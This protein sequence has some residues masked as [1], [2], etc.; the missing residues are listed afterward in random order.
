MK[1]H[2]IP[3]SRYGWALLSALALAGCQTAEDRVPAG[4]S[5][6]AHLLIDMHVHAGGSTSQQTWA[7][8]LRGL[9]AHGPTIA[10]LSVTETDV[11]REWPEAGGTRFLLGPSFPCHEGRYPR[12]QPCF[13]GTQGW[14]ELGWLREQ[15]EL[16]R[17][18]TMGELLYVYY[19]IPPTDERLAPYW[20]LA[21]ELDIPVG[22]HVGRGPLRRAPGCCPRFDDDLG[23]PLLLAPVLRRHPDL[24]VWLMHAAGWDYLD[25]TIALMKAH[26]NVYAELSIVNSVMPAGMHTTALR[27]LLDAG[28]GD[29]ILFGSDNMPIAP[30]IARIE[31]T[32]FLSAAQKR[33]IYHGNAARFLRIDGIAFDPAPPGKRPRGELRSAMAERISNPLPRQ[34]VVADAPGGQASP[35][36]RSPAGRGR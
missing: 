19:G 27:A 3:L 25:E 35:P 14:P 28:L 22:V 5:P 11:R 32:P 13:P 26:P 15:Y 23:D 10:V 9:G 31:A 16:G 29:R 21:E 4:A 24:R 34:A 18:H 30:I 12:M 2:G 17:M 1:V 20:R 33:A 36:A 6:G 8:V 7:D